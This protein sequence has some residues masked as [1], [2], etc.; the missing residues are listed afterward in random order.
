MLPL[1]KIFF[2]LFAL[3]YLV[4]CPILI[5]Y[6]LGYRISP[7]T[8]QAFVQSGLIYLS[9]APPG[10]TIYL[11]SRKY[12]NKTPAVI[13][14]LIPGSYEVKIALKK[15]KP[16]VKTVPVEAGKASV[17]ERILLIP[18]QWKTETLISEPFQNLIPIPASR[19][20]ILEK[21]D[22]ARD[23][24]L[25]NRKLDELEKMF[26]FYSPFA[27]SLIRKYYLVEK[28]SSFVM[29]LDTEQ[30]EKFLWAIPRRND[31]R[32]KEI[33][34]LLSDTPEYMDWEPGNGKNLFSLHEGLLN[35]LDLSTQTAKPVSFGIKGL[36]I[37]DKKIYVLKNNFKVEQLNSKGEFEK[38]LFEDALLGQKIFNDEFYQIKIFP[39]DIVLFFSENGQLVINRFPYEFVK[40]GVVGIRFDSQ[41]NR[42]LIW[43]EEA[44]GVID[45]NR[46]KTGEAIFE[47][48]ASIV[49]VYQH[50]NNIEQAFSVFDGFHILFRDKSE[51]FLLELETYGK[52][53]LSKILTVKEKSSVDYDEASGKLYY[54]EPSTG[55]LSSL[56]ILPRK[57]ILTL[58]FPERKEE[59]KPI[60]IIGDTLLNSSDKRKLSKVS[61]NNK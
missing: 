10:A 32:V 19:F 44:I 33:T 35:A 8:H 21:S 29:Q 42:L 1:R 36:G 5:L 16:W 56:E 60:Q 49:W 4:F 25:Y 45:F 38:N 27:D 23:L 2:Y 54:L 46:P 58:P 34:P 41:K 11:G 57:D 15:Y 7:S 51:L 52:P 48:G 22:H 17:L 14:N 24:F 50:G 26:P 3:G 55:S 6:A 59:Q 40:E 30:G 13:S 18:D 31:I 20:M 12:A 43:T 39:Q 47:T 37:H 9:T 61:P 28:S 53:Y